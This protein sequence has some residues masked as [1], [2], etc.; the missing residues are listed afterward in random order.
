MKLR[1]LVLTTFAFALAILLPACQD[2]IPAI[3]TFG[4]LDS[5]QVAAD[6]TMQVNMDRSYEYLRTFPEGDTVAYDL[7]AYDKPKG[8]SNPEWESKFIVIRRARAGQDTIVK[9]TRQGKVRAA[10]L[11]D[12]DH[13]GR[14]EL[15]FYTCSDLGKKQ[16]DCTLYAFET[17]G[18]AKAH[19]IS[20]DVPD[21]HLQ[22]GQC[23]SF[24]IDHDLLARAV[25]TSGQGNSGAIRNLQIYKLVNG[26]LIFEKQ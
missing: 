24:F 1:F 20:I 9:D 12:M 17:D 23:D 2:R 4:Q 11:S 8:S 5:A 19:K 13:N 14:S 7:L 15:L 26:K 16:Q 6:T 21:N 25:T 3:D 18:R 10:W 22:G